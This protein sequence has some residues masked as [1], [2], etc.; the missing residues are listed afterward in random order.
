MYAKEYQTFQLSADFR[1]TFRSTHSQGNYGLKID[2]YTS[3]PDQ[4]EVSF[5]FDISNFYGDFYSFTTWSNQSIV[6]QAVDKGYLTGLKKS[7]YLKKI[8]NQIQKIF[9]VKKE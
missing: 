2:F 6:L 4:E 1:T 7:L 8:L 9:I 5:T 3:D